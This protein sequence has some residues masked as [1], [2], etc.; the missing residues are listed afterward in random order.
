MKYRIVRCNGWMA[1]T[2]AVML[3]CLSTAQAKSVESPE[4]VVARSL[5]AVNVSGVGAMADFMHP[6]ELAR[7]K[8]MLMPVLQSGPAESADT[9]ARSLLGPDVTAES[10][11]G[12]PPKE[13]M[14]AL[15]E[16]SLSRAPGASIQVQKHQVLGTLKEG[17]IVHVVTR[18]TVGV[19][20]ISLTK[21]EVISVKPY[22]GGWGLM[23]NGN[24][25]GMAK[26]LAAQKSAPKQQGP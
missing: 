11:A 2:L 16:T 23:L 20:E 6:D 7:F 25:E 5:E 8:T 12:M 24:L 18:N 19:G 15:L 17:D 9:L 22:D 3:L 1:A 14:R 10:V 13:F 26:M 21:L 4:S